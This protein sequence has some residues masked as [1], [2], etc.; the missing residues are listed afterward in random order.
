MIRSLGIL[1]RE[2]PTVP[3]WPAAGQAIG[4]SRSQTYAMCQRG[5]F[6]A[7]VLKIGNRYR[8]VSADLRKLLGL[9]EDAA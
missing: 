2:E 5:E 3:A 9:D 7:R 1:L 4:A 8:V 6:P